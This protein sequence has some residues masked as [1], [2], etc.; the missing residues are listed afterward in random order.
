[1]RDVSVKMSRQTLSTGEPRSRV[2]FITSAQLTQTTRKPRLWANTGESPEIVI[3]TGGAVDG[4]ALR[5]SRCCRVRRQCARSA[6]EQGEGGEA[7]G[8]TDA[9]ST[10]TR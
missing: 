1:M 7:D 9:T 5:A 6:R 10:V 3:S 4:R 8:R 2:S